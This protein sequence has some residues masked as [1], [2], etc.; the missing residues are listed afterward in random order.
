MVNI[1]D[2][3]IKRASGYHIH[4][5]ATSLDYY[6]KNKDNNVYEGWCW[7]GTLSYFFFSPFLTRFFISARLGS[8]SWLDYMNPVVRSWWATQFALD[9]YT[10]STPNLFIWNDMNEPSVFNGPEVTMHKDAKHFGNTEHRDVH[11]IFGMW[12]QASTAVGLV[13]RSGGKERPFVLSR[14]FFAGSQRYGAIWTGDNKAD[15]EHLRISIPM[16]LTIGVA[17]L[18]FAG[19][20]IG[21]FFGDPD[22]ELQVRWLQVGAFYPF[23][24]AHA[25]LD[26]RRREAYLLEE[27]FR[28]FARSAISERYTYL[29]FIYTLFHEANKAGVPVMRYGHARLEGSYSLMRGMFGFFAGRCGW[30]FQKT[31]ARLPSSVRS[32]LAATFLSRP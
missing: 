13:E 27:P 9:K 18:P 15:W 10:G 8:S 25:H 16:L 5:A 14:A 28:G 22:A 12:Q 20:D 4:E 17:G 2:P 30:S 21:G 29:P 11:N 23:M 32:C 6:V 24:R 26:A 31:K 7:P 19:A 1:V 3:H